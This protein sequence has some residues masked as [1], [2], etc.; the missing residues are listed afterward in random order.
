[1]DLYN[2]HTNSNYKRGEKMECY[3]LNKDCQYHVAE[4]KILPYEGGKLILCFKLQP[5]HP[6]IVRQ[7]NYTEA[8]YNGACL[9]DRY[10]PIHLHSTINPYIVLNPAHAIS[11]LTGSLIQRRQEPPAPPASASAG[12]P[13]GDHVV[14]E[15]SGASATC[16]G[17]VPN[18]PLSSPALPISCMLKPITPEGRED[19]WQSI[20]PKVVFGIQNNSSEIAEDV[21]RE[22][23]HSHS[24]YTGSSESDVS[25]QGR[26]G[27]TQAATVN[28][29]D[30]Q[31]NGPPEGE[32]SPAEK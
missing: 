27:L 1:M 21:L 25:S 26:D 3:S 28:N 10:A 14:A 23:D 22:D 12:L 2:T 4:A 24:E 5:N 20:D 9:L 15:K 31:L 18:I 6:W 11:A 29:V 7:S 30:D 17:C 16:P 19:Q 8:T 32:D 13:H